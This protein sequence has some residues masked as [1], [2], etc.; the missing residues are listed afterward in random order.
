MQMRFPV[1]LL[2]LLLSLPVAAKK[3]PRWKEGDFKAAASGLQYKIVKA[4]K[5]DSIG[6]K[7]VI[8]FELFVFV[9]EAGKVYRNREE[10]VAGNFSMDD[11][12]MPA[13]IKEAVKL[14]NNGGKGYF[15]IPSSIGAGKDSMLCFIRVKKIIH[16]VD[17]FNGEA[18]PKDSVKADSVNF[19]VADPNKKYFGDTLIALMKLTELPQLVNCGI[20]RVLIAFKFEMTYFENGMQ[21]KSILIFV[22]CP[23]LY[24]K[25]YF[26]VGKDYMITCIPLMDDLKAGKRTMNSY[27]L[28]KLDSYYGLR[29]SRMGN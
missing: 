12:Q 8:G 22:E 23:E 2:L 4:G 18:I 9:R 5:A 3:G 15:I 21:R 20:S 13:G 14:L 10:Y 11:K 17:V 25:D 7:D 27:S 28:M 6:R 24:G 19:K 29:V 16:V 1:F 26:V